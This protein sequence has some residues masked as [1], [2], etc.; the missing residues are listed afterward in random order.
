MAATESQAVYAVA[1]LDTKGAELAYVV[2]C[3]RMAGVDV[4][5]VDVGTLGPANA[6][7]DVSREMIL[8]MAT[9]EPASSLTSSP[10]VENDRATAIA[11][12]ANGLSEY[13]CQ[14]T[15]RGRVLGVI[16]LGGS[17]GTSLITT[18][19]RRLPIGLPKIMVSTV[20]SGNTAPYVDCS[21]ICMVYSV[22]DIAGLN[23]VSEAVLGNAARAMVGMS[24][25]QQR[26]SRSLPA[27]GMTMFGVTTP[28]V[29]RVREQLEQAGYDCLVFH[30]TGAGGRAMEHLV[31]SGLISGILDITTTEVAD[32]V[33]GGV[34][35]AGRHRF[36]KIL[37]A[38]V[39]LVMSLGALDM[40]NF[41]PLDSVPSQFKD[42]LLHVH[43]QQVTLMRTNRDENL[44]IA[45]W[46]ANKLQ[47]AT[48]PFRLLIP[49]GGLSL[50]DTPGQPFYAPEVDAALFTRITDRLSQQPHATVLR[51]PYA[52]NDPLFADAL[53]NQYLQLVE[54]IP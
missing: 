4:R 36:D 17:G 48:R 37:R 32:E 54:S 23:V 18:A 40:V 25:P 6:T 9:G 8:A 45:D 26:A 2:E 44:R 47:Q 3:I 42:R 46:I 11:R 34:F 35:P 51:L 41:G 10:R 39:P 5:V 7:A 20:A 22:V 14:E 15:S 30:A 24:Q 28:C 31:A 29:T 43:N 19:M 27:L 52:I 49:E 53:V 38:Q 13:L 16:G 33:V 1:T 12:M 50:L 21:D